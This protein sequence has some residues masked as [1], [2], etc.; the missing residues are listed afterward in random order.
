[1]MEQRLIILGTALLLAACQPTETVVTLPI[2]DDKMINILYDVHVAE[3]ALA[4]VP[5]GPKKDSLANLY[6]DQ[7][8][9]LHGVDRE[10]LDSSLAMLQRDP[11]LT[12]QL[13]EKVVEMVEKKRLQQ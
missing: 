13:Y 7:L 1:M 2:G 3:A 5:G 9:E 4:P 12:R 10:A 11:E 6:Y 8:A